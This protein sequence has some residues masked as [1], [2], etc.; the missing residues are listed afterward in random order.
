MVMLLGTLATVEPPGGGPPG[1]GRSL[2]ARPTRV[3]LGTAATS[4][5]VPWLGI[6]AVTTFGKSVS[7]SMIPAMTLGLT[8]RTACAELSAKL[9]TIVACAG[10]KG[11][12]MVGVVIGKVAES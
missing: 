4:V 6:P 8:V 12:W 7:R 10:L 3:L 2:A 5:T 1:P 9:A 11:I